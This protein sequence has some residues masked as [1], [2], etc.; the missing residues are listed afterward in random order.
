MTVLVVQHMPIEGPYL[1]GSALVRAGRPL[2]VR[3]VYAGAEV[4]A[5]AAGLSGLV[6]MGGPMGAHSDEGFPTR[7]AELALLADAVER[8][9]PTLGVC[10]GAQLLAVAAGGSAFPGTGLEVGWA[11]VTLTAEAADDP[12]LGGLP[13]VV[14]PLHWHGDTYALPPGAVRLAGSAAYE[15]QAF[16]VG[17]S[18]WGLQAHLE[19]DGAG[20]DAFVTEFADEAPGPV[21]QEIRDRAPDALAALRPHA[22]AAFDRFA[23]LTAG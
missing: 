22:V 6:V 18:A 9:V 3:R 16:R 5:D 2:D 13:E 19:V 8:G 10:L 12:L 15:Q 23:A 11:P 7:R 20:V 1:L 17:R 14:E 21:G 4:P